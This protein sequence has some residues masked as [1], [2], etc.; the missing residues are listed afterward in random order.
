MQPFY[1]SYAGNQPQYAVPPGPYGNSCLLNEI[2]TYFPALLYDRHRFGTIQHVFQYI[3]GEMRNRFDTFTNAQRV[4]RASHRN[5]TAPVPIVPQNHT[6]SFLN[7]HIDTIFN[8]MLGIPPAGFMDSV[9]I[10]PNSQQVE[11][12]SAVYQT[13]VPSE[14]PCAICQDVIAV[15][16]VVRK[17]RGCNH[18]FHI[19]CIDTWY[20]RS[21]QCPT[22]RHDIRTVIIPTVTTSPPHMNS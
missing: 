16:N 2:H 6:V 15:G 3:H 4:Y 7:H 14:S 18:M 11:A 13:I 19:D 20:Q 10:T 1:N 9:V 5:V 12:G 21:A 22:C 17:L 8:N